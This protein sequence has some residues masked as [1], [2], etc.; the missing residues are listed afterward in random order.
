MHKHNLADKLV[1][2]NTGFSFSF[3]YFLFPVI[4]FNNKK[5]VPMLKEYWVSFAP[6]ASQS[7]SHDCKTYK[8]KTKL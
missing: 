6:V 3:F 8:V 1:P 4:H 2:Q 7:F 5:K